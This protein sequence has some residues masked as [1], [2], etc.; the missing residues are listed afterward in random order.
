MPQPIYRE[1]YEPSTHLIKTTELD[2][3]LGDDE[4][5]VES[6]IV[7]YKNPLVTSSVDELFLNGE[8]LELLSIKVDGLNANYELKDDGLFLLNPTDKFVLEVKVKIHPE[9]KTDLNGLYQSSGNFCTQCEA[10]GFRQITYYLDRPDVLSVFT[11]KI[12]ANRNHYPVLLSN[13]NLIENSKNF[14]IWHDPAPKPCYLFALVAGKLDFLQDEFIT[15]TGRKVDLRLYV[16]P[17]NMHKTSFAMES[18]KKAFAWDEE[19]FNLSYDLDI[20]MIVAV[21]DFNMGAMEN[22]GLNIFNSDCVLADKE[23]STD[24]SF[25]RIESI[26]GHEYFHN[27]TGNRVTCRDW[28][29]LS[30]KEGLTVFRDQEFSSDLR[31][32]AIQRISD[33]IQLKTR[34]FAEDSGPM[35]HPVR[36]ESYI[37][38][39]NFYT[40][41]VYEKGAEVIRMIHTILG[42]E[43]FQKGMKLYFQRHDGD[44]VTIDDFV[45]SMADA[46]KSNFESFMPWYSEPGTPEVG[47]EDEYDPDAKVYTATFTQNNLKALFMIPNR[48]GLIGQDGNEIK[49]GMVVIDELVKTISFENIPSKPTPSWF[50]GFSAPIK[51]NSEMTTNEKIFLVS[52]DTDPFNRW[53]KVQSLWL[54]FI[55]NPEFVS[56][57]EL[58]RMIENLMSKE[59]DLALLSEMMSLPSEQIIHQNVSEIDVEDVHNR[60]NNSYLE[61]GNKFKDDF[62]EAYEKLNTKKPFDL[63]PVSVAERSFKNICLVYLTR[64]GEFDIAYEQFIS[65]DCMTDQYGAFQSL[66]NAENSY[67][68]EVIER[69][70]HQHRSDVQVMDKW[71]SAQAISSLTS[72]RDIRNLMKHELFTIKNPNRVR[73]VIGSFSQN[74][75][76]FHCQDGYELMSEVVIELDDLNPQIAA[77]FAGIFNHWRRFVPKYSKLQELQIKSII[78]RDKISKDVFEIVQSA[79]KGKQ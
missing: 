40:S 1:D 33:V 20:Y 4:T 70:Y 55:L 11:T 60:R 72:V 6:K 44:A 42:E 3:N 50:R 46:N 25:V 64:L 2:F 59:N 15:A 47:F 57:K 76:Q 7:F 61:I 79:I 48:F 10:M 23:S 19:R 13:G 9:S 24:S 45:A 34:Q 26:I 73:S 77:R 75:I 30:L 27:W 78:D 68:D 71:F 74:Y 58:F 16:E 18:L 8:S 56:K 37:S 32:R 51:F 52:N 31:S 21:D 41:T 5:I 65:A 12:N 49:S 69:F 35:S 62:L 28:F 29:Q 22:K 63:S 17:H 39:D 36:P 43:G 14:S 66:L 53:D 38:M 67:R 54:D